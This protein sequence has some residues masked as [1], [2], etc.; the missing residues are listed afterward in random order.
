MPENSHSLCNRAWS[1]VRGRGTNNGDEKVWNLTGVQTAIPGR[2]NQTDIPE[3]NRNASW[4]E[5]DAVMN[6]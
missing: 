4:G 5:R 2:E 6:F 3:S 1:I